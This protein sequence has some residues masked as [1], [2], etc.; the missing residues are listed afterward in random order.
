MS[1]RRAGFCILQYTLRLVE[2]RT[3][4]ERSQWVT[5]LTYAGD[6]TERIWQQLRNAEPEQDIPGAL[7][8]FVPISYFPDLRMLVQVFAYDYRLPISCSL[9]V[10]PPSG[11]EPLLLSRF[12]PGE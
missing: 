3:G 1:Y 10:G 9:L 12:G 6:K 5:G 7:R 8:T 4:H 11:L 2:P